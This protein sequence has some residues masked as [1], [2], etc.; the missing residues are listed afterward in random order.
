M[1][2]TVSVVDK[3]RH[4]N[5]K[6]LVDNYTHMEKN[7]NGVGRMAAQWEQIDEEDMM[8]KR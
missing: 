8:K 7:C 4:Y 3:L 5:M 6:V 2:K 1:D